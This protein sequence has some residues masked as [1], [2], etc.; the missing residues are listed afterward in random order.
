[1]ASRAT[2]ITF[3]AAGLHPNTI[4]QFFKDPHELGRAL[5]RFDA[6]QHLVKAYT[7]DWDF[8]TNFQDRLSPPI[9]TALGSQ[10]LLDGPYDFAI[11]T[12]DWVGRVFS[13]IPPTF[14]LPVVGTVIQLGVQVAVKAG[15]GYFMVQA[16]SMTSVLWGLLVTE[17]VIGA[18]RDLLGYDASTF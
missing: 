8:L 10:A 17:G 7:V 13:A 18:R 1:V 9:Y 14:P 15:T 6:P 11:G 5:A 16:H 12:I 3:N 4:R 2:G